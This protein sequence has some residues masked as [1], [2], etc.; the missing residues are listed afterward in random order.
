MRHGA[1][2]S[3]SFAL[4]LLLAT[5]LLFLPAATGAQSG[6]GKPA[7][8]G[9]QKTS[10]SG[11]ATVV[12]ANVVGLAPIILSDTGA[13]DSTGGEKEASL[14]EHETP[15]LLSARVLHAS[16]V[17]NG[18]RSRSE[19]S[20]VDLDLAV[21]GNT[22]SADFLAARAEAVCSAGESAA[23]GSEIAN[24][25]ING[26]PVTVTGEPNQTLDLP[27]GKVIINEQTKP[28]SGDIT[29]NALHVIIP[30]VADVVI[31][32]AHA[33][34]TCG[35]ASCPGRDFVTGGGW[36]VAPSGDR[37]T[38]GVAGGLK[39]KEL[40]GHL[41]YIDHGTPRLRVKAGMPTSYEIAGNT[42]TIT[43][44]NNCEVNGTPGQ[45]CRVTVADNGE[46]GR[47]QDTFTITVDGY[48]AGGPLVG[49][50]I[51]LHTPCSK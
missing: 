2:Q 5:S 27:V 35:K 4:T 48:T 25:V 44:L 42:R 45:T 37:G 51:Q 13:L 38:F 22:I 11:R 6:K 18:N 33:D 15:G 19:A 1:S 26:Q 50:N 8:G 7:G 30:G 41:V 10:F 47:G 17:G 9:G 14:L 43:W 46:P 34:I 32:S 36:I 24:L 20:V 39:G 12:N 23:G 16:T 29:V 40:W 31:A 49:G 28:R 3:G 21:G